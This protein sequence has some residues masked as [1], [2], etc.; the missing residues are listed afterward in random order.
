M[1][2][3]CP[4]LILAVYFLQKFYLRTSRQIRFLDLECKSP[5]YTHVAETLEGLSTI[6]A[7]GWQ[8]AFMK[9]RHFSETI[10]SALLYPEMAWAGIAA[11]CCSHGSHCCCSGYEPHRYD[12]WW[13]IGCF[14]ESDRYFQLQ[15]RLSADVLDDVGNVFRCDCE[16]EGLPGRD[17]V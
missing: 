9:T 5:L 13:Q 14:F 10:L 17:E 7:F 3:T 15:L 11:S 16:A 6:R 2:L 4:V 1:A 8:E 12:E